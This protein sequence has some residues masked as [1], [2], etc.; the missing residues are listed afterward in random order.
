MKSHGA[1]N[2]RRWVVLALSG[3]WACINGSA[4]ME[5]MGFILGAAGLVFALSALAKI[6]KLQRQL[7]AAGILGSEHKP[8]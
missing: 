1:A 3:D 6:S 2:N 4:K 7:S 5:V 8:G